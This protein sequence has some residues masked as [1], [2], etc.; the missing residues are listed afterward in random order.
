MSDFKRAKIKPWMLTG[1]NGATALS[2][3]RACGILDTDRQSIV[4]VDAD[5]IED[6]RT[7]L[8]DHEEGQ[9][10]EP[11]KPEKALVVSGVTVPLAFSEQ[12]TKDK[13]M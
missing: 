11:G 13:L 10:V 4:K 12:A 2:I 5:N 9:I 8:S 1:D 7:I 3:A 6:L